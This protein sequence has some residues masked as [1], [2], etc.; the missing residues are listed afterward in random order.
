MQQ[1]DRLYLVNN[2]PE[3]TLSGLPSGPSSV[4]I[5]QQSSNRGIAS[6]FNVGIRAARQAGYRYVLLLDQDSV[7]PSG[8][9]SRYLDVLGTLAAAGTPVAAV[10][11]RHTAP[12]SDY[13]SSFVNFRWFRNV[14][15]QG[16][17]VKTQVAADFLISSGSFYALQTFEKVGLFNEEL[18]IDHVD[19]EWCHRAKSHGYQLVGL[20]D[21]AMRHRVGERRVRLWFW[22]WR[23][24]PIHKPFR[25]YF[26]T[27]NSLLLYRMAH[28]PARWISG[29]LSRLLRLV[30]MNI[31]FSAR[32][33]EAVCWFMLGLRD[34]LLK[35]SGP[36]P[37]QA[38]Q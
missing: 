20:W 5:I 8:M 38:S 19:T 30:V 32:R 3:Q 14:Y 34:G 15:R 1:V 22:G 11:P 25:L 17:A 37:R 28:V 7:P 35:V 24:Q 31:L 29:D 18:F 9:V 33:F 16:S 21:V 36:G 10:G 12:D 6:G 26:I 23:S 13:I 2:G 4:E 27:R